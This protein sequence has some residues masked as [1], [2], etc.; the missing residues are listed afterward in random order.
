MA[1][2][3]DG[4]QQVDSHGAV[5]DGEIDICHR[6]VLGKRASCRIEQHIES[7]KMADPRATASRT[8]AD[9]S[10]FLRAGLALSRIKFGNQEP[11]PFTDEQPRG[12]AAD[13]ARPGARD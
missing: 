8:L 1:A 5:P 6:A 11:R 9:S 3:M 4:A 7:T 2:G 12:A 10:R 13:A